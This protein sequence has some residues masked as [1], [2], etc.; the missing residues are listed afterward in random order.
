MSISSYDSL[1]KQVESLKMENTHLRRELQ[2]NS[3]HL[4]VLENE[5]TSMKTVLTHLQTAM[6]EDLD[7]SNYQEPGDTS[8]PETPGAGEHDANV[9]NNS[10]TTLVTGEEE[11]ELD[12]NSNSSI[13]LSTTEGECFY[14]SIDFL[15][16]SYCIH[17]MA[18]Q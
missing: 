11:E 1:L 9:T 13:N 3:S 8:L 6:V 15:T 18:V 2:D 16:A 17:Q 12:Q 10:G 7:S 5:A 4:T 14:F